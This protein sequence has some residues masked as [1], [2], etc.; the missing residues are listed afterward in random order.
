M[1][2]LFKPDV[3]RKL[4]KDA[5]LVSRD[6]V[7]CVR[8]RNAGKK[9]SIYKLTADGK[10]YLRP[11]NVWHARLSLGD[12]PRKLIPL[13]TC[14]EAAT[15]KLGHLLTELAE[16]KALGRP[17]SK[18]KTRPVAELLDEYRQH[19]ADKQISPKEIKLSQRRL[20]LA[21][22][23]SHL[24][25]LAQ[26]EAAPVERWLAQQRSLNAFGISTSNF[27]VKSLKTFGNWLVR[28][29]YATVNPFRNLNKLN[30]S[31]DVRRR[32]RALTDAELTALVSAARSG[33]PRLGLSGEARSM[34]Y[35]FC[36]LTGLRANEAA[37]LSR[38]SLH[39]DATPP[40]VVVE[41]GQ[42]KRRRT[43]RVPLHPGLVD[44]LR[45]Y[46]A[47]LGEEAPLWP[48]DWATNGDGAKLIRH[49]LEAAR[50][51]W[52]GENPSAEQRESE[53]LLA[54]NRAGEVL[55]FH[56]LRHTFVTN[57]VRAGVEPKL[58]KELA[59]HS[60]I[61][62][63][64]DRYAHVSVQEQADGVNRLQMPSAEMSF[65]RVPKRV[66]S[67]GQGCGNLGSLE[68]SASDENIKLCE[69]Q[70]VEVTRLEERCK[71]LKKLRSV[72]LEP[73]TGDLE[74]RCSSS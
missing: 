16:A 4:P 3:V 20:S 61:V 25:K 59:R 71:G 24:V 48:S 73:T 34:L 14:K 74:G 7:P 63:T 60:T 64:L 38:S 8:I 6:G 53:F 42:S 26:L 44:Q 49:D 33:R 2:T 58:A 43:D 46:L 11:S 35:L 18:L 9:A 17:L 45:S 47:S 50:K 51:A 15:V 37:T 54:R 31:V 62:L 13:G 57:L 67:A 52:L 27:Y 70:P 21:L 66:P 36:A 40:V 39:L 72:G 10:G 65:R 41:A 69:S 5:E 22:N 68:H 32:R 56:S 19:Q 55:D 28:E 29:N 12:G 30:A 23:G 1:P